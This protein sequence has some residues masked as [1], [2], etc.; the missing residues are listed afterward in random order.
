MQRNC[1]DCVNIGKTN[2]LSQEI[3]CESCVWLNTWKTDHFKS[4]DTSKTRLLESIDSHERSIAK[5]QRELRDIA[6]RT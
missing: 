6:N 4:R 1:N 5:L 3:F 2:A